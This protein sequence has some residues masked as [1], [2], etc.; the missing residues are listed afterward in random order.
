[1]YRLV[2]VSS[3]YRRK[4]T[5]CGVLYFQGIYV[6]TEDKRSL[7]VFLFRAV[8][9][10]SALPSPRGVDTGLGGGVEG[11]SSRSGMIQPRQ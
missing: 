6:D 4:V 11:G 5:L 7:E 1:M 9:L 3:L 10:V 2:R 8:V